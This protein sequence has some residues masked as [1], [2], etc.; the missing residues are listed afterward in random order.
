VTSVLSKLA[1]N[2]VR[3]L[4]NQFKQT[5]T[6]PS[7][8]LFYAITIF[9]VFFVSLVIS[10]FLSLAPLFVNLSS[11]IETLID[12]GMIFA[13]FG[14]ISAGSVV[15]GYFG[16]GPAA[17]LTVDQENILLPAPVL[18]YQV[19]LS[20]YIRRFIRKTIFVML[21]LISVMPLLTSANVLFLS[22]SFLILCLIIYLEANYFLGALSSY[23]R[24]FLERRTRS[25]LRYLVVIPLGAL[26]LLFTIPEFTNT[27][28]LAYFFPSNAFVFVLTEVT[29]FFNLNI[30]F[31]IGFSLLIIGFLITLLLT[32]NICSYDYYELFSAV[33]G[34]EVTEGNFSRF[35]LGEVDFSNSR[36]RDPMV[37]IILK[38]FY[39]RL[40]SPFQIWKY[41][42]VILGTIFVA[43]LNIAR[44]VW[45]QSVQV[46]ANLAF[47]VVPAFV[48][49]LILFIQMSS[50]TS[51]LS[52]V[53]EK[54]NVYLLKA[55][56]FKS[57]DV[58]LAKYLLSLFEVGIAVI[59][60]CGLLVYILRIEGYLAL[61]TLA[62]PL[63]IIFTAIGVAIGAYVPVLTNDPRTLPVPLAFS[64]PIV[65]L[66]LGALMVF[67]VAF[68]ANSPNILIVLP[69]Y[70]TSLTV[71]F[72]GVAT[73]A[74]SNYK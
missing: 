38:D 62:A 47:A 21:G 18:P 5:I 12:R 3:M 22:T 40:R 8:L 66:S 19:F 26:T 45:F 24:L 50:V 36:F 41:V 16:L 52:F 2:E 4:Y 44:P 42:Y 39:S 1:K 31:M 67:L 17:G 9:G 72:L 13:L 57:R 60:A 6:T 28:T 15:S 14:I 54:E 74:L 43:Y 59:P 29:G 11:I 58:V 64:Y 56:P 55:S 68:L 53:D 30:G 23:V 51:M 25:R 65:N 71:L 49:M 63:T 37:W 70:T 10:S 46:P 33:K 73:R 48:L 34:R 7:M 61:I 32:A 35:A 27:F 69:L 20:N